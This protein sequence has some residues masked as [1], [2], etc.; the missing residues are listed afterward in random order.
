MENRRT[1]DVPAEEVATTDELARR[2]PRRP[3]PEAENRALTSLARELGS[4]PGQ[5]LQKLTQAVL[6]CCRAESAG[7]SILENAP[8]P[9]RS[10]GDARFRWYA[11]AGAF[12][13]ETGSFLPWEFAPCSRVIERQATV[14][15]ERPGRYFRLLSHAQPEI[16]ESLL[17]PFYVDGAP[18]GTVWA[19][20]HTEGRRFDAEDARVLNSLSQF[21]GAGYQ[22]SSELRWEQCNRAGLEQRV[23]ERTAELERAYEQQ[24]L[25]AQR[26]RRYARELTEAEHRERKRIAAVLHDE[27]QQLLVAARMQLSNSAAGEEK[28]AKAGALID[29][30]VDA[31]RYLTHR[32]RPPVLYESGLAAALQW[33]CDQVADRHDITVELLDDA[34]EV[35]TSDDVNALLF[36]SVR[37]LLFNVAKY[38]GVEHATVELS[39]GDERLRIVVADDGEGFEPNAIEVTDSPGGFGLFSVRERLHAL[40]GSMTVESSPGAGTR[41]TLVVAL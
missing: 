19:V 9:E 12:A 10:D 41:V 17:V 18:V 23:R 5:L 38:A 34:G 39:R 27:L 14:L 24:S 35:S 28:I 37:E 4:D 31:S 22:L 6:E 11:V 40:G 30:A 2:P 13:D 1:S 3:E 29:Q 26:L 20:I 16:V 21:A 8:T 7:I 25:L 15:F 33:L 32:I 36:D